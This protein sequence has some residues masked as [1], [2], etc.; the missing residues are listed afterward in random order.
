MSLTHK[1]K[2]KREPSQAARPTASPL[3]TLAALLSL[4]FVALPLYYLFRRA[5]ES[6]FESL[7]LVIFRAKT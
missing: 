6:D 1:P 2:I 7:R 5:L 4:F 3:L